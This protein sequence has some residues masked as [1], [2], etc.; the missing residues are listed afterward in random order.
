MIRNHYVES[1][2]NKKNDRGRKACPTAVSFRVDA[3]Y[4]HLKYGEYSRWRIGK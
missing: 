4:L 3:R 1:Y 2:K